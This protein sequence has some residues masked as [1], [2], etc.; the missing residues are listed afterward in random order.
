MGDALWDIYSVQTPLGK[1]F[2]I[3]SEIL[4]LLNI[5]VVDIPANDEIR[6]IKYL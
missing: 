2:A 6:F 5:L 4:Q 3:N 1:L